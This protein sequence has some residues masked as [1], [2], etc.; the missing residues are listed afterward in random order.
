MQRSYGYRYSSS[1]DMAP[2]KLYCTY[3][4]MHCSV[5]TTILRFLQLGNNLQVNV[6]GE[7]E[8]WNAFVIFY[9]AGFT[10]SVCD[11]ACGPAAWMRP[12]RICCVPVLG[13][14]RNVLVTSHRFD[15]I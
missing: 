8:A 15:L 1:A 3:N 6:L 4:S 2:E 9:T 14:A 11:A 12:R 13:L 10:G 5:M 7:I